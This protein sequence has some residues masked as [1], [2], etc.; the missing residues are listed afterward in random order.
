MRTKTRIL[1]TIV[2]GVA[3]LMGMVGA[4]PFTSQA[5]NAPQKIDVIIGFTQAPG[6]NGEALVRGHGG[7]IKYN[8]HLVPAIAASVSESA[9]AGLLNNPRITSID[10]DGTVYAID[11]EL[12]NTWGVKRIGSGTVHDGGNKGAGVKIAIIDSGIDYNHP[13]LDANFAGGYD[14]VNDDTDPMDDNKHGTH[15]AGT[16]AA[17]DNDIGVV[18]VAPE[19]R[20]Y[21]LK[22]LNASGSG[23]WSDVIAALEWAVDNGIQVTN[24]SYGSGMNPGGVVQAAFDSSAAAGIL[25]IAAAG[26]AGNLKGKGNNVGYPARYDSVVAV[27]AT[28][29]NDKRAS[30]SST[31]PDVE[32]AAPGVDIKSTKLGGGY[33]E[34]NGTSMASPHVAGSAALVIAAG[35]ADSNGNG[36]INDEV[37]QVLNDTALDLGDT[38][39]D[40]LYGFGLVNVA[41]AVAA[42]V[43]PATG[44][45]GGTVTDADTLDPISGA[46]VTDGTRLATTDVNGAYSIIDVPEGTYTVTA[47]ATGYN[48]VSQTGVAVVADTT[49]TVDFALTAIVYGAI[50]GT[51]TDVDTGNPVEG[52]TVTDGTR[53]ATTDATGYYLISDVPEGTYTVT[54][55]ATGYQDASQEVA[56]TGGTTSTANFSLQAVS[57]ASSVIVDSITYATEGGKNNDKHL[58]I[59]VALVDDLG[60]AVSGASVS[61]DLSRDGSFIAS[62]TGTTGTD[63]TLTF[64][65]KNAK[66]GCYETNVT[67]VTADGLTWNG[68]TPANGFCK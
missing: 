9:I 55:G 42:V 61:I 57:T 6:L 47:S 66:S 36:L 56:V 68:L 43:P 35:I 58:L 16:V 26:N 15:V 5:A 37:R 32:L 20:L 38:G 45:I 30:F 1:T 17:E 28:D 7:T 62:G 40:S 33:I 54:A 31:G 63:G 39:R 18:G 46:T 12:D 59:T 67:N 24:N 22:V 51:V 29:I 14:F 25:H 2:V 48:S 13:D 3:F 4:G 23:S 41:A 19:A 27:A 21:A 53:Q 44:I 64:S 52:A 8:Y 10:L 60:N 11:V 50:D 65:L 34:F 49:T